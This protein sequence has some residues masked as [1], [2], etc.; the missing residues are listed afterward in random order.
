[1]T[2]VSSA[3]NFDNYIDELH[4]HL[5]HLHQIPDVD[6]QCAVLIGDLAEAFS[7]Q[8][9]AMQTGASIEIE[10]EIE[11]TFFEFF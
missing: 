4:D 2:D 9:S 11:T 10:I 5:D 1:M 3:S 8:P 6:D 7:E